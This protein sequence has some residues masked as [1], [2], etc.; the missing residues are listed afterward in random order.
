VSIARPEQPD[1][2][3]MIRIG[4]RDYPRF[5]SP[6][7]H[8]CQSPHRLYIEN[9]LLLS[10]TYTSIEREIAK[11]PTGHLASPTVKSITAHVKSHHMAAPQAAH[12]RIMDDRAEELG[13]AIDGTEQLVDI[14]VLNKMILAVGWERFMDDKM[15]MS[16]SDLM[17]AMQFQ[18]KLDTAS[19]QGIDAQVMQEALA[20][21]MDV[22]TEFIPRD[23]LEEY[24]RR[25]RGNL[26]LRALHKRAQAQQH[27]EEVV[28]GEVM[29]AGGDPG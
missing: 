26:V 23:K 14:H 20:I 18:H 8:T 27:G 1:S 19:D 11:M 2:M 16:V 9:Q 15:T 25:L 5:T 17:A 3:T 7:C 24:G 22:A 10:R 28:E 6:A 4:N 12:R 13:S 21:Y 29:D